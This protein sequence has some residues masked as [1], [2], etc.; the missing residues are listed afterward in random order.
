MS[1]NSNHSNHNSTRHTLLA[2]SARGA[3]FACAASAGN[4]IA[5]SG[6][7]GKEAPAVNGGMDKPLRSERLAARGCVLRG[8]ESRLRPYVLTILAP[9]LGLAVLVLVWH[10][11]A[12]T[13]THVPTPLAICHE[14]LKLFADLWR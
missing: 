1:K 7:P 4:W 13:N 8:G 10:I 9:L 14:A 6:Q 5:G 2:A 11:V 12:Q 3:T